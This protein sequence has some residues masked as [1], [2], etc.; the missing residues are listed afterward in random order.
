MDKR[1]K[2]R[3]AIVN[4]RNRDCQYNFT[5]LEEVD[6]KYKV[7]INWERDIYEELEVKI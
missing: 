5:I 3:E 2:I 1:D 4:R 6:N 7:L